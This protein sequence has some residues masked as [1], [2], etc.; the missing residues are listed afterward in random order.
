MDVLFSICLS[1][2][3]VIPTCHSQPILNNASF[4]SRRKRHLE[5]NESPIE[6]SK[7]AFFPMTFVLPA[8]YGLFVEQFKKMPGATWIMKPIGKAQGKG[9]FLFNRLS[10]ISE[11]KKDHR[12][13][14]ENPQVSA[15]MQ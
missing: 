14:A 10:Q 2:R 1:F 12:W 11:W 3:R 4:F 9:I 8:E 15:N 6:A 7:F 5:R 13:K